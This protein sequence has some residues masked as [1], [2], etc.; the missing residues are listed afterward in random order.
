MAGD[1]AVDMYERGEDLVVEVGLPG[2]RFAD[3]SVMARGSQLVIS[4]H[5]PEERAERRYH[6]R[7]SRVRRD[8]T[9]EVTLPEQARMDL[10]SA[11]Y[12]HGLLRVCIPLGPDD[13]KMGRLIPLRDTTIREGGG[14]PGGA[15]VVNGGS[16]SVPDPGF[17]A[18][19]DAPLARRCAWCGVWMDEVAATGPLPR[20]TRFRYGL[21]DDCWR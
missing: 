18:S 10:A 1:W 16:A 4:A 20:A 11:T 6:L 2:M 21:C 15:G 9:H 7:G 19:A 13:T 12:A 3:V 14:S 17:P 8:F 5:S